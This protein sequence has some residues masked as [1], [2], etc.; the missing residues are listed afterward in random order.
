[1]KRWI[2]LLLVV[3]LTV[4]V[5]APV[6]ATL[7]REGQR[8]LGEARWEEIDNGLEV[9]QWTNRVVIDWLS[10]SIG[11]GKTV[12]FNQPGPD[13]VAL[14][15]VIGD[16]PSEI[17]GSLTADGQVFLVNPHGVIFGKGARVDVGGL[18]ASA[19]WIDVEDPVHRAFWD[20]ESKLDVTWGA[21]NGLVFARRNES[22]V[23]DVVNRGVI[24]AYGDEAYIFLLGPAVVRNEGSL[25]LMS[26]GAESR[27]GL[28]AGG[29]VQIQDVEIP[30]PYDDEAPW[31]VLPRRFIVD[32]ETA[33]ALV[34]NAVDGRIDTTGSA[35]NLVLLSAGSTKD[36]YQSV[37][38]QQGLVMAKRLE[39]D[40]GEGGTV[41]LGGT[42]ANGS[43]LDFGMGV[44][45]A[46]IAVSDDDGETVVS[47][48]GHLV[49][50][51]TEAISIES[52]LAYGNPVN[53]VV[54]WD[55][56]A[57]T[58]TFHGDVR[59]YDDLS[60][61]N[62]PNLWVYNDKAEH[63]SVTSG[64]GTR[65]VVDKLDISA[66]RG[67]GV[68]DFQGMVDV[69]ETTFIR[70]FQRLEAVRFAN[71]GNQFGDTFYIYQDG[72]AGFG[73]DNYMS[74]GELIIRASQSDLEVQG[75]VH[76]DGSV[77][78]WN[79]GAHLT[80]GDEW[81]RISA[82]QL[83]TLA[84]TGGGVFQNR[85]GPNV[86]DRDG[87]GRVRIYS[88]SDTRG[89]EAGG[90]E[91]WEF[92]DLVDFL[93]DP[94]PG[95]V[96]YFLDA[97]GSLIVVV[98]VVPAEE[99]YVYG[100]LAPD[101]AFLVKYYLE[102]DPS[103]AI[104]PGAIQGLQLRVTDEDGT[105]YTSHMWPAL[106]VG[107][108]KVSGHGGASDRYRLTYASGT[109]TVT[110]RPLTV[111]IGDAW[112]YYGSDNNVLHFTD[113]IFEGWA[114]ADD[115][116]WVNGSAFSLTSAPPDADVGVY[117]ITLGSLGETLARTLANYDV[118]V[119]SGG[120]WLDVRPRPLHVEVS[121][122]SR[123]YG[124]EN[125]FSGVEVTLGTG[126]E[127]LA[128]GHTLEDLGLSGDPNAFL[129]SA[130]TATHLPGTYS[131]S[132]IEDALNPLASNYDVSVSGRLTV[133][134]RPITIGAGHHTAYYLDSPLI[135]FGA[136]YVISDLGQGRQPHNLPQRTVLTSLPTPPAG[137]YEVG[138]VIPEGW[139]EPAYD[140]TFVGGSLTV[141]PRPIHINV[142]DATRPY[143]EELSRWEYS[144]DITGIPEETPWFVPSVTP[145]LVGVSIRSDAG[146]YPD[147]ISVAIDNP[148]FD[149]TI[150]PGSLTITPQKIHLHAGGSRTYGDMT[151][152]PVAVIITGLRDWDAAEDVVTDVVGHSP[153]TDLTVNAGRYPAAITSYRLINDNY[154]IA[155]VHDG[156]FTVL[157]R[158]LY[159][160]VGDIQYHQD[161]RKPWPIVR[162]H[163]LAP[164]DSQSDLLG[165]GCLMW[166]PNPTGHCDSLV[167]GAEEGDPYFLFERTQQA[168]YRDFTWGRADHYTGPWEWAFYR[169]S[170]A[171]NNYRIVESRLGHE[172]VL[173]PLSRDD[174]IDMVLN[175]K[176]R[177]RAF[178]PEPFVPTEPEEEGVLR[179]VRVETEFEKTIIVDAPDFED[180]AVFVGGQLVPPQCAVIDE[181]GRWTAIYKECIVANNERKG[182]TAGLPNESQDIL[183]NAL[184]SWLEQD[185][186][187]LS[188]TNLEGAYLALQQG[189]EWLMEQVFPF[190]LAEFHRILEKDEADLTPGERA[191]VEHIAKT[192]QRE[193]RRTAYMALDAY[194][195]WQSGA[196]Q[197][198]GNQPSL[199]DFFDF[200]GGVPKDVLDAVIAAELGI[201]DS[202]GAT[203]ERVTGMLV[204]L[205]G[206]ANSALSGG[207][208]ALIGASG[209]LGPLVKV[210]F[211]FAARA[212][213]SIVALSGMSIGGAVLGTVA[214]AATMIAMGIMELVEQINVKKKLDAALERAEGPPPTFAELKKM[215][216][217]EE[218][219]AELMMHQMNA[220]ARYA[221]G[222]DVDRM[223]GGWPVPRGDQYFWRD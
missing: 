41:R 170:L 35:G 30:D 218:G 64:A 206:L 5:S 154:E 60:H 186:L 36:L 133:T 81:T 195:R 203:G 175:Q 25:T 196:Q 8:V 205:G 93:E 61:S 19:L 141:L 99:S 102:S 52:T 85:A 58:V 161:E 181:T 13:A 143:G 183:L 4:T 34:E 118:T 53:R 193:R 124:D 11:E 96:I 103:V 139:N 192:M 79:D 6:S 221:P 76:A 219:Q 184:A 49:L 204:F 77:L 149:P 59:P 194:N 179:F 109:F 172:I 92:D 17:L 72:S 173:P 48:H 27:I 94:E 88:S 55:F 1:M 31:T 110:H 20:E 162:F 138:W 168:R 100:D 105:E 57:P 24:R 62:R 174:I 115:R 185:R 163:N 199:G 50:D 90:L 97:A 215:M 207:L 68:V 216:E 108:Y 132:V 177:D 46:R 101:T 176:R 189:D 136:P 87:A 213:Q 71:P 106:G 114:P 151:Y 209:A 78:I 158:D 140:V 122:V 144:I 74:V 153:G 187:G 22:E 82:D 169:N 222:G 40:G 160:A 164:F 125:D 7:P 37:I 130:A 156:T 191:Y 134:K 84:A 137:D 202:Y 210:I 65:L 39:I 200:G 38:N 117:P 155:G 214:F 190:L 135:P 28:A 73:G 12:V 211:P 44:K 69:L 167:Y 29:R 131:V 47:G 217:T 66:T 116:P 127:G 178:E 152:V 126:G 54:W 63:T 89:Y 70:R 43:N 197:P 201:G 2:A 75:N 182:I 91:A 10:F 146:F 33:D 166:L 180:G 67:G 147:A 32:R 104:D 112:R 45:G 128:P 145:K 120:G 142:G 107:V 14:N 165:Q 56:F 51:A 86:F 83:V 148:N 42:Y 223:A 113:V 198:S 188:A 129:T 98:E 23:G 18:I 26:G 80:L 212:G 16:D 157:P 220:F 95:N 111:T 9:E 3:T 171:N 21:G 159:V 15:R 150:S 121:A 123:W 208:G 119:T